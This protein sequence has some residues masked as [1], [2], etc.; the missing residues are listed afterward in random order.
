MNNR[1]W[2]YSSK[3]QHDSGF[4]LIEL[5]V[6]MVVGI[7]L[8][9]G[10]ISLVVQTNQANRVSS[11]VAR[12]QENARFALDLI[13]RDVKSAAAQY[14]SG[15]D[16]IYPSSGFNT[17]RALRVHAD[18]AMPNGLPDV[19]SVLPAKPATAAPSEPFL[20]SPRYFLQGHECDAA[21]CLPALDVLGADALTPPALGTA[22]GLRPLRSDVL[23][24]RYVAQDGL[25]LVSESAGSATIVVSGDPATALN[26][27]AGDL[28]MIA[29][30][31]SAE[32]FEAL[33]AGSTITP[34]DGPD[35]GGERN[36]LGTFSPLSDARVFNFTRGF[37]TVTYFLRNKADPDE[38]GRI[39]P[40]LVRQENGQADE[41]VEGIE[42]L[43][44]R[45]VA[46]DAF[47][48]RHVLTAAQVQAGV[49]ADGSVLQCQPPPE[50]LTGQEPA[51]LWRSVVGV[52]ISML[53]NTVENVLPVPAESYTYSFD[54][55]VN[56]APTNPMPHG[57][58]PE[59][60]LRREFVSTVALRN[61]GR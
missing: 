10:L 7:V 50:G 35:A 59:R 61:F 5:M 52:E 2:A 1:L 18:G 38:P 25:P 60:M 9:G 51:C 8:L 22:I 43:D 40:V 24:V 41:L 30:C 48:A 32:V 12:M 33:V 56:A 23:T 58:P 29:D 26:H 46:E 11:G 15:F 14:C 36:L 31:S 20:L 34:N 39:I 3:G 16:N 13:S 55:L 49:A 28:M 54:D 21:A 37:R 6:A 19:V 47:N 42:R 53:V 45:Y 57:L 17:V 44:F 27:Q 4:T